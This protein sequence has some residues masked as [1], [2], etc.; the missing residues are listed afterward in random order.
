LKNGGYGFEKDHRVHRKGL[1]RKRK[2]G[3]NKIIFQFSKLKN[4]SVLIVCFVCA[5]VSAQI[6]EF[7]HPEMSEEGTILPRATVT[8][9]CEQR[10]K[11]RSTSD[12]EHP[13]NQQ[14]FSLTPRPNADEEART[15]R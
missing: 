1:G 6:Y 8:G 15:L 7:R 11:I 10:N 5:C 4:I 3:N 14:A 13:L 9:G 12:R 2:Q